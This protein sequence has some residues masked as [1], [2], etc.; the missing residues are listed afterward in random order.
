[1]RRVTTYFTLSAGATLPTQTESFSRKGSD[2]PVEELRALVLQM[3]R[4]FIDATIEGLVLGLITDGASVSSFTESLMRGIASLVES[5]AGKLVNQVLKK[6]PRDVLMDAGQF[7]VSRV[8]QVPGVESA[9]IGVPMTPDNAAAIELGVTS[10]EPEPLVRAMA[11]VV[12][13]SLDHLFD[14]A[15]AVIPVGPLTRRAV[16]AGGHAMRSGGKSASARA[17]RRASDDERKDL[18]DFLVRR[19]QEVE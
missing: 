5:V 6:A 14:A 8:M 4:S 3:A 17:I 7:F 10:V 15:F 1:V 19:R 11:G 12:D 13:D 18:A 9:V 16:D 2:L